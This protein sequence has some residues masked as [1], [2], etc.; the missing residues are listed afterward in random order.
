MQSL[1]ILFVD[2]EPLA[3]EIAKEYLT[4]DGHRVE[5]AGDGKQALKKYQAGKLKH[6]F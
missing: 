1:R 5:T 4:Q 3:Q 6:L 2:D